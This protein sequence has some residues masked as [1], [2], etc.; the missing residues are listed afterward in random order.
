M[1]AFSVS[2]GDLF[3]LLGAFMAAV[4]AAAFVVR[5][6]RGSSVNYW[7]AAF[8]AVSATRIVLKFLS[9]S[10]LILTMPHAWRLNYPLGLVTPVLIYLY[11]IFLLDERARFRPRHLLH[12]L[13]VALLVAYLMPFYILSGAEKIAVY[14][15]ASASRPGNIPSWY[16]PAGVVY[17]I[18]Y[19]AWMAW[20][21]RT[22]WRVNR[23]R[24]LSKYRR[25]AASWVAFVV[26]GGG[27]FLVAAVI[28]LIMPRSHMSNYYVFQVLSMIMIVGCFRLLTLPDTVFAG[29][30]SA[31]KYA[32]TPLSDAERHAYGQKLAIA[33]KEKALYRRDGLRLADLASVL[34]A[35]EPVV[36]QVLNAE[37]GQSFSEFVNAH[38]VNAAKSFL[39]DPSYDGYTVEAIG[40]EAGFSSR[41][42]FYSAFKRLT[43]STPT[44]YRDSLGR[45]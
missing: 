29:A 10:D 28:S 2:P 13:P 39:N 21:L 45:E 23:G 6:V 27:V 40:Q 12:F 44:Q 38:R 34:D 36:S 20:R 43:G 8:P 9:E 7:L 32:K 16:H 18:A 35:P 24:K 31:P 22:F 11:T 33:M 25:F 3:T 5:A 41:A 37:F 1:G 15:G 17:S 14:S 30:G 19:F 26:G 4:M 42:T